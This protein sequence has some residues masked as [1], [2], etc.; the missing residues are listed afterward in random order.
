MDITPGDLGLPQKEF[1]DH[2]LW[3]LAELE[4]HHEDIIML[5]APTGAGKTVLAAAW[6]RM[7]GRPLLYCCETITLQQQFL[8]SFPYSRMVM[9]RGHY[10]TSN[11]PAL[12]PS[13]SCGDCTAKSSTDKC[14]WC[15]DREECPY[16]LAREEALDA[17]LTALNMSY[18][19]TACGK[20]GR[21]PWDQS[22][23]REL[24][25]NHCWLCHTM[26][27]S[28]TSSVCESCGWYRCDEC[29]AC[30]K[31]CPGGPYRRPH[32]QG[33]YIVLDEADLLERVLLD[34]IAVSVP[35][36]D[37][38]LGPTLTKNPTRTGGKRADWCPW[39]DVAVESARGAAAKS[40]READA[41][42][43]RGAL[44]AA[45]RQRRDGD[46]WAELARRVSALSADLEMG[47]D[48][49]VLDVSE[50]G[51]R[52]TFKPIRLTPEQ[53]KSALWSH[54]TRFMLMSGT[55]ISKEA[56]CADL[57]IDPSVVGWVSVPCTYPAENRRVYYW[58]VCAATYENRATT[59]PLLVAAADRILDAYPERT[60][61]HTHSYDL[62]KFVMEHSRFSGRMLT[63]SSSR[64]REQALAK[65]RKTPGAV[66]VAPSMERGI[67][68]P[69][70]AGRCQIILKVPF[71]S[72]GDQQV[73]ARLHAPGGQLWYT[74][75]TIRSIVQQAGRIVRHPEDWGDTWIIDGAFSRMLK[76][77]RLFPEYFREALIMDRGLIEARLRRA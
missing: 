62:A 19:I 42:F 77:F 14:R 64:E 12:F 71:P 46:H 35:A 37:L 57:G 24:Y 54:G 28:L 7:N 63:Y 29:G 76:N 8:R 3:A 68:L 49:W 39:L 40:H 74:V 65:Y 31:G 11:E 23:D 60:L 56:V 27:S 22:L 44:P 66:L 10:P 41:N 13:V 5:D 17:E 26:V 72:L 69:G 2:Q 38:G 58:P 48:N 33:R 25:K 50:N 18:W 52:Y 6:A 75:Q 73:S 55:L 15:R 67:D 36:K 51:R 43:R 1:Y 30:E 16:I 9:G 32:G 70:D 61:L 20:S 47:N 45:A 4:D 59:R 21:S 53:T 34:H